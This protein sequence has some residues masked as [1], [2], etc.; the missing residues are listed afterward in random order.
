MTPGT[1]GER[2][3]RTTR[4]V[5]QPEEKKGKKRS[6]QTGGGD[7]PSEGKNLG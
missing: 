1:R 2:K 6:S 5:W 3:G 4:H 7:M